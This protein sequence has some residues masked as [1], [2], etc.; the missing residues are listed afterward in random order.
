VAIQF[1]GNIP[2]WLCDRLKSFAAGAN[3]AG[4]FIEFY[5]DIVTDYIYTGR[6]TNAGEITENS[7]VNGTVTINLDCWKKE[8]I[9]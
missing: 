2:L 9:I 6:W 4:I 3:G 1:T 5:D 8:I 7:I